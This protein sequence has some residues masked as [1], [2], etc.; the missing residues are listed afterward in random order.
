MES[1]GKGKYKLVGVL[2]NRKYR[3]GLW[4]LWSRE[5]FY[6]FLKF[7]FIT[8]CWIFLAIYT[9][10]CK[11]GCGIFIQA[12]SICIYI[13]ICKFDVK[14]MPQIYF[15]IMVIGVGIAFVCQTV[16]LNN[17]RPCLILYYSFC[18][19]WP[20]SEILWLLYSLLLSACFWGMNSYHWS[21]IFFL[22]SCQGRSLLCTA[23]CCRFKRILP[24]R[25]Q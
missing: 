6:R 17:Y 24:C 1:S 16:F 13:L 14:E 23:T 7:S 5:F 10:Y 4:L 18:K 12:L 15:W 22:I 11:S 19:R 3:A 25:K 21:T 2:G 8:F 20:Y 9:G